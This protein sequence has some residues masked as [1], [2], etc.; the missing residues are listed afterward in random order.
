MPIYDYRCETCGYQF[1]SRHTIENMHQPEHEPC[2]E[3]QVE[4]V[5]KTFRGAPGL[6]DPV[7]I[8][9]RKPD[10]GFKEV[11]QKIHEKTPGSRL[12]DSSRYI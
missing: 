3:C 12:K 8:G 10:S 6:V 5:V 9:L 11:L 7:R 2:P 4:T 1:E